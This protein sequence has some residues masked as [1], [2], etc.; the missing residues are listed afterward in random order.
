M[1]SKGD[2]EIL[3]KR[4][5]RLAARLARLGPIIQG[6]ITARTIS[7]QDPRRPGET[8]TIGPYYQWTFKRNAK[9]VT[10]NLSAQQ[11]KHFQRAIDN[12]RKAEELLAQM[13]ELSLA[14]LNATTQGVAK[15]NRNK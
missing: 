2:A 10:V 14:I 15:R 1:E 11:T 9:T 5:E 8:I 13:R 12:N 4:H 3:Q 6:S 7:K